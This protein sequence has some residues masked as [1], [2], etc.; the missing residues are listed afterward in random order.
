MI[1]EDVQEVIQ[2]FTNSDLTEL[3]IERG[4]RRVFL[5]KGDA[6]VVDG[7]AEEPESEAPPAIVVKA[8]MV[9]FFYWSK[10]KK[11]AKPT[12]AVGDLLEKG[13]VVGFIEAM[14]LM[15]EV[16]A[17]Q[18]GRVVDVPVANA[19]PVEYGQPLVVFQPE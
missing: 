5:R 19:Q 1:A 15:N 18:T 12:V 13:K 8:H 7:P 3:S 2:L 16:E 14:G 11:A 4:G 17:A 6:P 9:G 10:D